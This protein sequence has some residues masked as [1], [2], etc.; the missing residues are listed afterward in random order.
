MI[1]LEKNNYYDDANWCY[2]HEKAWK[3]C[4]H[5]PSPEIIEKIKHA[6]IDYSDITLII[7]KHKKH[8]LIYPSGNKTGF[9]YKGCIL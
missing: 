8:I 5:L 3:Y 1:L 6:K 9:Y 4:D 7:K 2:I